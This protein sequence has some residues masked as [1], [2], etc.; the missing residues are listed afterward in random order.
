MPPNASMDNLLTFF[1]SGAWRLIYKLSR[2]GRK[3]FFSNTFPVLHQT[4]ATVLGERNSSSYYLV[5]I[6]TK[7]SARGKGYARQLIEHMGDRADREGRPCYLESTSTKNLG[8]YRRCGYETERQ[9]FIGNES[10]GG[11]P[12]D[13]MIREPRDCVPN[14]DIQAAAGSEEVAGV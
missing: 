10:D 5:Y 4:K 12:L 1:R 14:N 13:I 8:L 7:P 9:I 6:G 11:V 3:R 2:I